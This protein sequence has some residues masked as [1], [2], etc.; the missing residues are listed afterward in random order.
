MFSYCKNHI[1]Y[2]KSMKSIEMKF[3]LRHVIINL[4][5]CLH[6][7]KRQWTFIAVLVCI[8]SLLTAFN[9][10]HTVKALSFRKYGKAR[11]Q[12]MFSWK[13][14]HWNPFFFFLN[15][16]ATDVS[17]WSGNKEI[18]SCEYR[19]RVAFFYLRMVKTRLK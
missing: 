19:N 8:F 6:T 4:F 15:V 1:M 14:T 7:L 3:N 17:I 12:R 18:F 9:C 16:S 2:N 11:L 10:A 5:W 13:Y